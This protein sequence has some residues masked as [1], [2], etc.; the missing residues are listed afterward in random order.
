MERDSKNCL[1]LR[2]MYTCALRLGLNRST[3]EAEEE[4]QKVLDTG[5]AR[6]LL[7]LLLLLLDYSQA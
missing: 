7:G 2:L 5:V 6:G 3:R 1:P 4:Q